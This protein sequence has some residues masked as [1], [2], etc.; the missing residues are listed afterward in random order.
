MCRLSVQNACDPAKE[1]GMRSVMAYRPVIGLFAHS[2][3]Q[4]V[5]IL[6]CSHRWS[7]ARVVVSVSGS[8]SVASFA[9]SS[10]LSFPSMSMCPGTHDTS[11]VARLVLSRNLVAVST[12]PNQS[13]RQ[14][15]FKHIASYTNIYIGYVRYSAKLT[16]C[17]ALL[18]DVTPSNQCYWAQK[19]NMQENC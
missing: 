1:G 12:G 17:K 8:R 18:H 5:F 11:I 3:I 4:S 10:A 6:S 9:I 15:I 2:L 19:T 7:F 16:K 13:Y 14:H